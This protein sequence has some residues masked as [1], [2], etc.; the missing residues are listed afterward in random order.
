MFAAFYSIDYDDPRIIAVIASLVCWL[1]VIVPT[2]LLVWWLY[3]EK[4][5]RRED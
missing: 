4:R 1:F 3:R 5:P 2:V